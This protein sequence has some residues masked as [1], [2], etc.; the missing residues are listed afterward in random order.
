MKIAGFSALRHA[1]ASREHRL[2]GAIFAYGSLLLFSLWF[3]QRFSAAKYAVVLIGVA[4]AA[5][6][7]ELASKHRLRLR[8]VLICVPALGAALVQFSNDRASERAIQDIEIRHDKDQAILDRE[9]RL[10]EEVVLDPSDAVMAVKDSGRGFR[11]KADR[12]SLRVA[13]L[14]AKF[15]S[16]QPNLAARAVAFPD[17]PTARL[18]AYRNLR[19]N[20]RMSPKSGANPLPAI[21]EIVASLEQQV[22]YLNA[23]EFFEHEIK[24]QYAKIESM[25]QSKHLNPSQ[26]CQSLAAIVRSISAAKY[27]VAG[28][29]NHLGVLAMSCGH[30]EEALADFYRGLSLD[31]DHIPIYESLAYALWIINKDS[32]S[33]LDYASMGRSVCVKEAKSLTAEFESTKRRYQ[34]LER[35]DIANV[36]QLASRKQELEKR[37]ATIDEHYQDFVSEMNT[38]LTMDYAYFSAIERTNEVEARQLMSGLLA[39]NPQDAEYQDSMGFILMRFGKSMDD[40][41]EANR[42]FREAV[43]NENAETM[44]HRLASTHLEELRMS[45]KQIEDHQ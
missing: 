8:I 28:V 30:R 24:P 6:I 42:L 34:E 22:T 21:D 45:R 32:Q 3:W 44:T 14:E 40:W 36:A 16:D 38:R 26:V 5:M 19:D 43:Q 11:T 18:Q 15:M 23:A 4:L 35:V 20:Q 7:P 13:D 25:I 10:Q 12:L 17:D 37:S 9:A 2:L 39:S 27:E 31:A 41:D 1:F 29:Y 33:A